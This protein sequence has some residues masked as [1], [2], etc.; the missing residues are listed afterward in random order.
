M[1]LCS[2]VPRPIC[3]ATGLIIYENPGS[4]AVLNGWWTFGVPMQTPLLW[5]QIVLRSCWP[6]GIGLPWIY[7][8]HH[9]LDRRSWNNRSPQKRNPFF[10]GKVFISYGNANEVV[11]GDHCESRFVFAKFGNL[12]QGRESVKLAWRFFVTRLWLGLTWFAASTSVLNHLLE[13]GC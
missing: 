3:W 6:W 2:H 13:V 11:A 9:I 4:S 10:F 1:R 7:S 8:D 5:P 12:L